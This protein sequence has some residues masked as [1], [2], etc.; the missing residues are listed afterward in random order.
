MAGSC[1]ICTKRI[2]RCAS[3]LSCSFCNKIYH[4]QCLPF[5]SKTDSIFTEKDSN[6]WFCIKCA[7]ENLPF[8]SICDDDDFY[9]VL[10]EFWYDIDMIL[11][12]ELQSR[13]F[14]P[15]EINNDDSHHPL[16]EV[17]PDL[18]YYNKINQCNVNSDYYTADSFINKFKP[19]LKKDSFSLLHCNIRSAPRNLKKLENYLESLD[20]NFTIVGLSE[21]WFSDS[22]ADLY[23]IDNYVNV[24]NF[25]NDKRGGGVSL[26]VK[27]GI[28][29]EGRSDLNTF[30]DDIESVFIEVDKNVVHSD[31]NIVVGVIYRP[32]NTNLDNFLLYMDNLL[33]SI[34]RENKFCY[35]LGDYNLNLL[36]CDKHEKTNQFIDTMFSFHF[37]PLINKPTRVRE[38]SATLIDN[39]FTNNLESKSNQG[40]LYTDIT[41]HFPI[42]YGCESLYTKSSD[43]YVTK[44]MYYDE[45]VSKF[46]NILRAANWDD[47]NA[48][49]DPQQ[50]FSNFHKKFHDAYLQSFPMKTLKLN[51]RNRKPWLT[52]GLKSAIKHKNNLYANYKSHPTKKAELIYKN[53]NRQLNG[54]LFK[55]ER[56]HY[57][58]LFNSHKNNMKK[59]WELIGKIINK[60]SHMRRKV[61][62]TG[63]AG[64]T[65]TNNQVADNFNNFFVNV[66]PS[67]AKKIPVNNVNPLSYMGNRNIHCILLKDVETSEV[68]KI[69]KE[70]KNSSPGW[71]DI[72]AKIVKKKPSLLLLVH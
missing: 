70:M 21:T 60:K 18:Q 71:D 5:V 13:I 25:R 24:N 46:V 26:L 11:I 12:P 62:F 68:S 22:T 33:G 65:L 50:A 30:N 19:K 29:F 63:E 56:D 54:I 43:Q 14:V 10:S 61:T 64:E 39:I 27:N 2:S 31:K 51:Y 55:A 23:S 35:L 32:P 41:D 9:N 66:G 42:F 48:S 36:N 15:F 34:S 53:Y 28:E 52:N 69:I 49:T 20:M 37:A 8:N 7:E 58:K 17:D 47:V 38:N 40:I 67:L 59:S 57:D 1:E 44:R 72:H 3:K 6:E 4:I 16:Y 45:N